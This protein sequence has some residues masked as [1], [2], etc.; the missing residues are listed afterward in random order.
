VFLV[1]LLA[2]AV[3]IAGVVVVATGRGGELMPAARD[4]PE[5]RYRLRTS[6]DVSVLRLPLA[7]L[8]YSEHAT[9]SAL[10][11]IAVL[12][13]EKDAEISGLRD[14][15]RRL[16]DRPEPAAAPV[17]ISKPA[18]QAATP[19]PVQR[20]DGPV[21]ASQAVAGGPASSA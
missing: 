9:G 21:P 3:I 17:T 7:V 1:L 2:A 4:L 11:A 15:V 8:G 18:E 20:S 13:A 6:A 16:S 12:L 10:R 14:E 19:D 5:V